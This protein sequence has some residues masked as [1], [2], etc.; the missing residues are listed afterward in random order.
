MDAFDAT[1]FIVN[2]LPN[3]GSFTDRYM[4]VGG[5]ELSGENTIYQIAFDT[6][7]KLWTCSC[8]HWIYRLKKT[9]GKCKHIIKLEEAL[10]ALKL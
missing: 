7:K 4:V 9:R 1:T 6:S 3:I 5:E 10:E 8:P 2:K